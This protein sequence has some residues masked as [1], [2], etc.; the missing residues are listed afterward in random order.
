MNLHEYKTKNCQVPVASAICV[1]NRE[2]VYWRSRTDK[3][4]NSQECRET[5]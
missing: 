1:S 5:L 2:Y 3:G 4:Y